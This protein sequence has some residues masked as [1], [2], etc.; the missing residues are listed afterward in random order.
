MAL[1]DTVFTA[2]QYRKAVHAYQ[3]VVR[4]APNTEE[5]AYCLMQSGRCHNQLRDYQKALSCYRQFLDAY[6]SSAW[7]D[8]ALIR[9]GVIYVGPLNQKQ[10]GAKLYETIL[11][12]YP[13]GNQA[14]Q[15]LVHLATL[16]AW[17]RNWEK[18]FQL[19]EQLLQRYPQSR[20][21]RVARE[22]QI[23]TLEKA[24]GRTVRQVTRTGGEK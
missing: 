24:L 16:A 23:P 5:A 4:Q 20:F 8:D 12:R 14:D 11:E 19:Y 15:A 17:E 3:Q 2:K 21:V 6:K 7:A 18:S 9:A 10:A 1:G 22:V 13:D